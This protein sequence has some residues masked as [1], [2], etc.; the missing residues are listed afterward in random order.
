MPGFQLSPGR[1]AP[2]DDRRRARLRVGAAGRRHRCSTGSACRPTGASPARAR[3]TATTRPALRGLV[4]LDLPDFDSVE[5]RHRLEVDRLLR[6]VDLV[7][8][9]LDPQKYAD[10]VV[11]QQYLAAVPAAPA[12]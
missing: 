10:R 11:H 6:L 7:V 2:P 4:L 5:A 8:W 3:W 12:T 9:V 1:G